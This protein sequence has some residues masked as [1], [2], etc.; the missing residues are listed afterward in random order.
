MRGAHHP[1]F[2]RIVLD[3]AGGLPPSR[4]ARYVDQLV[5]DGSGDPITVAGQ[6]ILR[7][8]LSP[9]EAHDAGGPTVP[10]NRAF[11]LPNVM[12]AVQAGDFEGVTTY[13]IGLEKRT[14]FHLF[15]QRHPDRVVLDI[16]A[17]FRTVPRRVYLFDRVNFLANQQPFFTPVLRPVQPGSPARGVLDRL[18]A[19]P[20]PVE[21]AQ[22]LRTLRSAAT[23]FSHLAVGDRVA[24]VRLA[25]GCDSGG[26]TVGVAG[27]IL[28]TLRQFVSVDWV[29]VFDPAGTT[30]RPTGHVDSVPTCLE[31]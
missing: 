20:V 4:Q 17:D 30:E 24:R 21:R 31:P 11:S 23:G 27:E 28:P 15:T 12:T 19:G 13:G 22:G 14:R 7:L 6:A 18:F 1:G 29:K 5:G 8:R 2:D 10:R 9:A 25:G 26:S 16:R 3:F